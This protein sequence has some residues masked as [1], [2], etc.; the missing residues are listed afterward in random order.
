MT[1]MVKIVHICPVCSSTKTKFIF[2]AFHAHGRAALDTKKFDYFQCKDCQTVFLVNTKFTKKYYDT[3]Y[4]FDG[5]YSENVGL[6]KILEELLDRYSQMKK[7]NII[8]SSIKKKSK[9][10]KILDVGAGE[11]KFLSSLNSNIFKKYGIE[12]DKKSYEICRKKRLTVYNED[13]LKKDFK[14]EKFTIITLW[15]VIEHIPNPEK[16]FKK[17]S[18][19]LENDGRIIIA[20]P[21]I[22]SKGFEMAKAKWFHMDAPRHIMLFSELGIEKIT[23]KTGFSIESI[24]SERFEFPLDLF[25]SM[26]QS[27]KN[28]LLFPFLKLL[29]KET[30]TYVIK[31][32]STI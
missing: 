14:K 15:H 18:A 10:I 21:N 23:K 28:L 6:K 17:L 8:T 2:A 11:G 16:L 4:N 26:K 27:G 19:I 31:K 12:L 30:L 22:E 13:I 32:N 7:Q 9:K 29:D 20:T 5:Y 24:Q 25:W 3:Y 1:R